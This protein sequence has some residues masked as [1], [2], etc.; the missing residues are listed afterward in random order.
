MIVR[1]RNCARLTA[2]S[3]SVT[4]TQPI[5]NERDKPADPQ[6]VR[7]SGGRL[8]GQHLAHDS[9]STWT[10]ET[11]RHYWEERARRFARV[12]DGL[13]AVCSYGMPRFYNAYIQATQRRALAPLLRVGAGDAVLDVGCGVGRWSL[14]MAARGADVTGID[15][16]QSMVGEASRRAAAGGLSSRC[17]FLVGDLA[18]LDLACRFSRITVV[19]VL[20]HI[21]EERRLREAIARL[22]RHLRPGGRLVAL[23]AAPT[24][25][26]TSCD[27]EVFRA[28]SEA[29]YR[30]RFAE[31]GLSV[32]ELRGVDP[33]PLKTHFLPYYAALP[34]W[35]RVPALAAITALSTPFDL[36]A[37]PHLASWSWH[38]VFVLETK[39]DGGQ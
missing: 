5:S 28:R 13:P 16:S 27:T 6:T 9:R 32:C 39:R 34:R 12:E 14:A 20:Q 36:L 7:R 18:E 33:A 21:L 2:K 11:A 24:R 10:A 31:A 38:K 4:P 30:D 19:T 3:S 15:L 35:V 17:R 29:W 37:S 1:Q 22:V 26:E 23:E 25:H 8:A